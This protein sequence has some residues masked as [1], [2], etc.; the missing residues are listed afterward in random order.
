MATAGVETGPASAMGAN[1]CACAGTGAGLTAREGDVDSGCWAILDL[2]ITCLIVAESQPSGRSHE[3]PAR[4]RYA[5]LQRYHSKG[6]APPRPEKSFSINQYRPSFRAF[7]PR[8]SSHFILVPA[9]TAAVSSIGRTPGF[10][11]VEVEA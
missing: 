5:V 11:G 10:A 2:R 6:Q 8:E 1:K 3:I 4:L 9:D 7:A